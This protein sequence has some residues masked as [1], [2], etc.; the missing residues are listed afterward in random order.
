MRT[1]RWFEKKI[2]RQDLEAGDFLWKWLQEIEMEGRVRR[3]RVKRIRGG[4]NRPVTVESSVHSG[5]SKEL[6]R[7]CLMMVSLR[8]GWAFCSLLA[9]IILGLL[10]P[11][12]WLIILVCSWRSSVTPAK[13]RDATCAMLLIVPG[14]VCEAGW[15]EE[16]EGMWL[17]HPSIY[18][19]QLLPM[20]TPLFLLP[21]AQRENMTAVAM[22]MKEGHPKKAWMES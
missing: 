15:S 11:V 19:S 8:T 2:L 1:V 3:G 21:S 17:E 10:M 12:C 22:R 9:G 6:C 4:S 5:P 16:P 18:Q 13:Q 7:T 14:T 20:F